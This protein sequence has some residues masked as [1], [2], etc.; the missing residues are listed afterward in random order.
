MK[1]VTHIFKIKEKLSQMSYRD[2]CVVGSISVVNILKR[3]EE[4]FNSFPRNILKILDELTNEIYSGNLFNA[5][6]LERRDPKWTNYENILLKFD[7][8]SDNEQLIRCIEICENYMAIINRDNT[9]ALVSC[10]ELDFDDLS[11]WCGVLHPESDQFD[12]RNIDKLIKN[13]EVLCEYLISN[14]INLENIISDYNLFDL[15]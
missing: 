11:Y 7:I 10:L 5:F 2:K 6:S 8:N 12:N 3:N 4:Y 15:V 14:N 13:Q 1:S 9:K